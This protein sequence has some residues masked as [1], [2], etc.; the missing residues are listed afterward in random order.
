MTDKEFLEV[1]DEILDTEESINMETKLDSLE[2]WDSLSALMFQS[3]M[4]K[5]N[6]KTVNPADL[7]Q[8]KTIADLY[9]FVKV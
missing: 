9:A 6:K 8:A 7:R 2:E 4:F 3:V 1:M 5:L